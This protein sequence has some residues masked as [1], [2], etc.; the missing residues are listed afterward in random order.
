[1]CLHLY[2]S[3]TAGNGSFQFC[4]EPWTTLKRPAA[5]PFDTHGTAVP[6]HSGSRADRITKPDSLYIGVVLP[7]LVIN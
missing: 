2:A 4:P 3:V 5:L 1:M 6:S 7:S